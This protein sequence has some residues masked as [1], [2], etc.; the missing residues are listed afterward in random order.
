M[1]N[2]TQIKFSWKAVPDLMARLNAA[3][4]SPRNWNVDVTTFAGFCES[5]EQLEAHI[6]YYEKRARS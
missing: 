6:E 3:Q 4:N 2:E 1:S 5:R